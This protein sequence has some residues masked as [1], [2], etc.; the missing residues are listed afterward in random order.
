MCKVYDPSLKYAD[1]I[2]LSVCYCLLLMSISLLYFSLLYCAF[3]LKY[4][5]IT[6]LDL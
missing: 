6:S 1:V 2:L 3:V 5:K 4:V